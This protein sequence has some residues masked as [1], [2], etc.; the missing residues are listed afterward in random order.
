VVYERVRDSYDRVAERYVEEVGGE[1]A[2]KPL[3]RA[4]LR[5]LIELV[6]DVE[7]ATGTGMVA[8]LGCGPGHVAAYLAAQGV[9]TT[10]IDISPAMVEV[11]R[12][13][14]PDVTFRV[15]S[16]LA[17][18]AVDG[19]M[20]A[21]IAFYSIIHLVPDDRSTAYREMARVIRPG[22]WLLLAFHRS[23]VGHEPG[24]I[25]QARQW[26]GEQVDLDFYYLEPDAVVEGVTA[27]GFT[28]FARTDRDPCPGV[29]HESRRTYL[30]CRRG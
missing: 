2:G 14:Y 15:G 23:L 20:A 11:G 9:A 21:A 30:L 28:V 16:L 3:D 22:G 6:A 29:E 24:E 19:E 5:C 4:L 10:G 12:R 17:L 27:A 26:W 25:M 8:D 7:E 13:R 1:L 18:P